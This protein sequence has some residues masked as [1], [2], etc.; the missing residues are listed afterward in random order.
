[1]LKITD[2]PTKKWVCSRDNVKLIEYNEQPR[3]LNTIYLHGDTHIIKI[4]YLDTPKSKNQNLRI[5]VQNYE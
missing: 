2:I 3:I 4:S 5:K 1:M